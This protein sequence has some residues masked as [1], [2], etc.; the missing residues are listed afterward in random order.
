MGII[1]YAAGVWRLRSLEFDVFADRVLGLEEF[2]LHGDRFWVGPLW[3]GFIVRLVTLIISHQ[4]YHY[5]CPCL[6]E[7]GLI[8]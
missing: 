2:K 3:K 8:L 1:N 5:L 4:S 7:A 6:R